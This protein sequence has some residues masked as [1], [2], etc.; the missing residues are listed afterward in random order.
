MEKC[1][2]WAH[3]WIRRSG[4]LATVLA[5][6]VTAF[7]AVFAPAAQASDGAVVRS[8][9]ASHPT[10]VR[11][12]AV[13]PTVMRLTA[14]DQRRCRADGANPVVCVDQNVRGCG[15]CGARP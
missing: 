8:P 13:R 9:R 14:D 1:S 11:P 12:I 4:A 10:A 2:S 5:F 7:G 6:L 15:S 3:R